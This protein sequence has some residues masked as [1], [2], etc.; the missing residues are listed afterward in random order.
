MITYSE[1]VLARRGF[2]SGQYAPFS[3]QSRSARYLFGFSLPP[4]ACQVVRGS[5][6]ITLISSDSTGLPGIRAGP[7][8]PPFRIDSRR[9]EP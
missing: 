1:E 2:L 9:I 5:C 7:L 6:S 8:P 3:I 4:G